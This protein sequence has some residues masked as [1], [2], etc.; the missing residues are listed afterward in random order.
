MKFPYITLDISTK[1]L[2]NIFVPYHMQRTEGDFI[3]ITKQHVV[4][5]TKKQEPFFE[6]FE[7]IKYANS[8][9]EIQLI[10]G[11][12]KTP[13]IVDS[14]MENLDI[15]D[16]QVIDI[17]SA[18]FNDIESFIDFCHHHEF[19]CGEYRTG[20]VFD[21]K[22]ERCFLCE[23]AKYKGFESLVKYNQFVDKAVDCIIYESPNF[24]V[25]SELG[26]L[27]KGFLM[28]V[29][30]EHILSVAQFPEALRPEYHEVCKDIEQ[31]LLKAFNGKVV[32]FFEHGSGPSGK[33]SHKKSIVHAHTHVVVDFTLKKE[34][35]EMVQMKICDNISVAKDVHYFSYQEGTDG[36]LLISMNPEVYVQRQFPRQI[37]AEEIG[38]APDQYNWRWY[39]FD[40]IADTTLFYLNRS[41]SQE[42]SGRIFERTK[43]FVKGFQ[44]RP[45]KKDP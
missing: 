6:H 17:P 24:Y 45:R 20:E 8:L 43:D 18:L 28:I 16:Y 37:M 14:K 35:Q 1:I 32:S 38:L 3:M 25:V 15:V 40:E 27:K 33:T 2:Y 19:E 23:L 31:I 30:K 26:T 29:P 42:R 34:Y 13:I 9:S 21:T 5:R 39:E 12:N 10:W 11:N 36:D 7:A 22:Q 4:L 41:L 44:M